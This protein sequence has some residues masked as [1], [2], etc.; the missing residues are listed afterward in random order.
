[1]VHV[2][3]EEEIKSQHIKYWVFLVY[4]LLDVHSFKNEVLVRVTRSMYAI[5]LSVPN[6]C[7]AGIL[8]VSSCSELPSCVCVHACVGTCVTRE[9]RGRDFIQHLY[10]ESGTNF[11]M[12]SSVGNSCFHCKKIV[13]TSQKD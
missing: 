6:L 13:W 12:Q 4:Y 5:Y 9:G 10:E 1:V 8:V 11:V 7:C 3:E 2:K